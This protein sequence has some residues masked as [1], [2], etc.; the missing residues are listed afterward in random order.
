MGEERL[1]VGRIV[2]AH[3]IHGEC[4]VR[5]ESD[6]PDRFANGSVLEAE[7]AEGLRRLTVRASRPHQGRL[8]VR[9]AQ[10]PDRNDAESLRGAWLTIPAYKAAPAP[11]GTYYAHQIEGFEVC[12]AGGA[13]LGTLDAV[14]ES[15]AHDIWSVRTPDGREVL[16]PAVGEF[17]RSV[18]VDERRIVMSPIGGM[19]D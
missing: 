14:L 3:G 5:V 12:D 4:V 9:F 1:I 11:A 2:R 15:P 13:L 16:V 18:D 7:T 6:A 19:F 8:L 17:I 10:V